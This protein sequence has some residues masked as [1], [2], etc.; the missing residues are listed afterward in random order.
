MKII[1]AVDLLDGKA[2]QLQGGNPDHL[3]WEREDPVQVAADWWKQGADQLHIIDLSRALDRGDNWPLIE[4]ILDQAQGP[5][6]VGGGLRTTHD[7][8][9]IFEAHEEGHAVV[10]TKAWRDPLWLEHIVE[11]WPGHIWVALELKRGTIAVSGWTERLKLTL[12]EGLHRLS[13]LELGGVLFTD[14]D[15][16]GRM[17]GPN[18]DSTA[19]AV[20]ALDVP[21]IVSGGISTAEHIRQ[22]RETGADGCI[23]GTAL[24]TG[25]LDFQDALE[26]AHP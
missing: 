3:L 17:G 16:E 6:T 23:I 7:L 4:Q 12:E 21:V 5:V 19:R 26:A 25:D 20:E 1:P 2:V 13:G 24:Y 18:L 10:A 9:G 8:A 14:V 11:A 22:A 15:R